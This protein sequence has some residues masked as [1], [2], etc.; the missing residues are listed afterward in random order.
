[1]P[2]CPQCGVEYREGFTDCSDCQVELVVDEPGDEQ[3]GPEWVTIG[4]FNSEEEAEL[5]QGF[6]KD[7]GVSAEIVDKEMHSYPYGKGILGEIML[8]VPPEA[9]EQARELL[10]QASSGEA[11]T[12]DGGEV[13]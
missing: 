3:L 2:W 13:G 4:V 8:V 9:E 12:P 7:A 5:A 10:A 11:S 6:L 1:M